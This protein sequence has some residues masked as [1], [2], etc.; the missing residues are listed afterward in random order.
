MEKKSLE[1]DLDDCV[2][3]PFWEWQTEYFAETPLSNFKIE[4]IQGESLEYLVSK[5]QTHRMVTLTASSDEYR[6]IRMT[7][8]DGGHK[9]QIF[10][11]VCY[12]RSANL[13][14]LACDLLQFAG[15]KR[16]LASI[17]LQP[18]NNNNK[19]KDKR[20]HGI[21]YEDLLEPIRNASPSLQDQMTDRFFDSTKYFSKQEL[22]GHFQNSENPRDCIEN[23]LFPAFQ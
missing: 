1:K 13:P 3:M 11:S 8:M 6:Y 15:G 20:S 9:S 18:M 21:K 19:K 14:I 2:Y 5:D 7:Y 22:L 23:E 17:D 10:T 16:H 12:P 4:R